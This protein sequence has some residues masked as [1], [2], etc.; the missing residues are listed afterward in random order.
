MAKSIKKAGI[1]NQLNSAEILKDFMPKMKN[2][3]GDS[4]AK[5]IKPM[6][7]KDGTLY[8][9]CLSSVLSQDLKSQENR[10]LNELN[11]NYS[12]KVVQRLKFLE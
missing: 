10:I 7:L 5:K 4:I 2:I 3:F 8:I 12:T 11:R 6:H 9:A 1:K